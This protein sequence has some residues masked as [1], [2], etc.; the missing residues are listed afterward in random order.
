MESFAAITVAA[1]VIGAAHALEP[2]H[3][4]SAIMGALLGS[5][6]PWRDPIYLGL[7]TATG[8]TLGVLLFAYLTFFLAHLLAP[9]TMRLYIEG[10][11]GTLLLMT[12]IFMFWSLWKK[13]DLSHNPS[14]CSCCSSKR[15]QSNNRI[16]P[17]VGFLIGLVPCPSLMALSLSAVHADSFYSITLL[18]AT[19]GL[20]VALTLASLGL[21]VTHMS[22]QLSRYSVFN[23]L[24]SKGHFIG[25]AVFM[26]VGLVLLS[27]TFLHPH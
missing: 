24:S 5:K 27:H 26:V 14:T 9:D 2:G 19:F 7:A 10:G 11:I 8:H 4:K 22:G 20:G 18:A 6:R 15:A 23:W 25:P 16:L 17:G 13:R 12:G 21:V 3:G 1:F